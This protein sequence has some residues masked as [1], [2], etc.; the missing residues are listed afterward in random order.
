MLEHSTKGDGIDHKTESLVKINTR[1]LVK[2]FSNKLSFILSNRA[3]RILFDLKTPFFAHYV[4]PQ[5]QENERP[6]VI[7]DESIILVLHSLNPL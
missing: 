6:S 3:I 7:P 2:A 4:L 1:L 5:A